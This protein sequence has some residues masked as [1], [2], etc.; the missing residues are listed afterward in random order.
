LARRDA[1]KIQ[2]QQVDIFFSFNNVTRGN[3]RSTEYSTNARPSPRLFFFFFHNMNVRERN[4][5]R[6]SQSSYEAF[7]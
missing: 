4:Y 3:F 5:S 1:L 7:D 2:F 6:C